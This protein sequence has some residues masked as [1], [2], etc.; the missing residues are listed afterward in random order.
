MTEKAGPG[1]FQIEVISS[2]YRSKKVDQY[3]PSSDAA[4]YVLY[5]LG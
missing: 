4:Q 1:N 5:K 2:T 3:W